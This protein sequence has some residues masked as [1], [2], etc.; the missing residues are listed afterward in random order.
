M[1][2]FPFPAL[3]ACIISAVL[4][5]G[6]EYPVEPVYPH[7]QPQAEP[8][9]IMIAG[10]ARID[11]N[12]AYT[13]EA[14]VIGGSGAYSYQWGVTSQGGQQP[15]TTTTERR[16]LLRVNGTD[17]DVL[18]KLTVASGDQTGVRSFGVKNC[19]SGC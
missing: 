17:G 16:L 13:W 15:T 11:A 6:C 7:A 18:L 12:G 5:I 3:H 19:I 1:R 4:L 9:S 10:P 14:I 2:R 8:I